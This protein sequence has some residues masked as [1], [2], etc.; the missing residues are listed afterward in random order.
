ML[1]F[2]LLLFYVIGTGDN[3]SFVAYLITI[4]TCALYFNYFV[5]FN[6]RRFTVSII[7]FFLL[8]L[9]SMVIMV[10]DHSYQSIIDP[11]RSRMLDDRIKQSPSG[12][13]A[14]QFTFG[15]Q[16]AAFTTFAVVAT[17][18]FNRHFFIKTLVL[19]ICLVFIY[20]GMN[21]SAFVSFSLA[22]TV[23]LLAYYRFKAV[24]FIVAVLAV[25]FGIYT[26]FLKNNL[27]DKNNI[28]SKNQA[29]E[30]NDFNR[31]GMAVENLK[32]YADYPYGL[33][34]YGKNWEDATYRNPAFP[35]GLSSHNAYLMFLTYL[36]PF[37]CIGLLAAIYYR[38][39]RL[40]REIISHIRLKHNTILACLL[41]SFISVSFNALSH[42]GWLLTADGPTLFLYFS[43]MQGA[44]IYSLPPKN[45]FVE[46]VAELVNAVC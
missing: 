41:F 4:V 46:N 28:L 19:C 23:F 32:V 36:G 20:L 25:G 44:K 8:L 15:Y 29:K 42:N 16:I 11:L 12:L 9:L 26:Y 37:L 33:I 1:A 31:A 18:V 30:A 34:F 7:I 21:R 13:A 43:L 6:K 17:F 45:V 14:T 39:I 40:S 3:L 5:G 22:L 10:L 24:F 35:F 27:D 38:I 2:G